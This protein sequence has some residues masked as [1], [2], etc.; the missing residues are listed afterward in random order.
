LDAFET[1]MPKALDLFAF[2]P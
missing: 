2:V 1:H